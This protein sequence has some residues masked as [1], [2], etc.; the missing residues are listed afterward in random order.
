MAGMERMR[1]KLGD[2]V[3]GIQVGEG[4]GMTEV[5]SSCVAPYIYVYI[6]YNKIDSSATGDAFQVAQQ[7]P[8]AGGYHREW[9]RSRTFHLLARATLGP[10]K[11]PGRS[12]KELQLLL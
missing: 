3:E 6:N 10:C 1:G 9:H 11:D 7:A 12:P 2:E 4:R 5:T 8:V